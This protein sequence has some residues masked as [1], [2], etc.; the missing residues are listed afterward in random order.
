MMDIDVP[1]RAEAP[2]ALNHVVLNARCYS[3]DRGEKLCS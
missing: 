3:C 1:D 2:M